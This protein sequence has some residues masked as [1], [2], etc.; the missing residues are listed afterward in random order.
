M[1]TEFMRV[2]PRIWIHLWYS[3][4]KVFEAEDQVLDPEPW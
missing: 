1:G 4:N 3:K 2:Y